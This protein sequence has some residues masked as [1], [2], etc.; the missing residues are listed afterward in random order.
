MEIKS[1][2]RP[3]ETNSNYGH[4]LKRDPYYQSSTWKQTKSSFKKGFSLLPNGKSISNELCY[5]CMVEYNKA[6]PGYAIDHIIPIE[7]GGS[8]TDHSNL[9]NRCESHH[10]RKSA[11][12][13]NKRRKK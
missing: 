12:E 2:K 7:E 8:R 5:D 1:I 13:G 10:N 6:L 3:W 4:R 11:I 9:R